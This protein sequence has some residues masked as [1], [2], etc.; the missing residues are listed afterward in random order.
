M[1]QIQPIIDI[2][3]KGKP[4]IGIVGAMHGNESGP[5]IIEKLKKLK[6]R[7]TIKYIIANPE[8]REKNVRFIDSDLNRSFPGKK[9]GNREERLAYQLRKIGKDIDILI[10]LHS[11]SM[12]SKP[13]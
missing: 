8:A 7:K 6:V 1:E 5:A 13:F 10:D 9:D 4:V 2:K 11:C 3:G 12:E